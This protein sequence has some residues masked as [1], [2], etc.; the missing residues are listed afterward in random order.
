MAPR[1]SKEDATAIDRILAE[2]LINTNI[3]ELACL[4]YTSIK[5]IFERRRKI[6]LQRNTSVDN[7]KKP[8]QKPLITPVIQELV[9][10]LLEYDLTMYLDKIADVIYVKFE[11]ELDK[12]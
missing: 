10:A 12:S 9:L 6:L 11:V 1:L 2:D 5:T 8:S 4:Y 3:N 7:C